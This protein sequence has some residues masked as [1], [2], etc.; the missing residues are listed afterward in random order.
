VRTTSPLCCVAPDGRTLAVGSGDTKL[1]LYDI[2]GQLIRTFR[3]AC[4]PV[5]SVAF[6]RM[7]DTRHGRRRMNVDRTDGSARLWNVET[8]KA[9]FRRLTEAYYAQVRFSP[10]GQD[11]G[12]GRLRSSRALLDAAT[13][14]EK[15]VTGIAVTSACQS[16]RRTARRHLLQH[17]RHGAFLGRRGTP[18]AESGRTRSA[19]VSAL[20][21]SPDGQVSAVGLRGEA[22]VSL[23]D[24]TNGTEVRRIAA[25]PDGVWCLTS[26]QTAR[27]SPAP[28]Q[29]RGTCLDAQTGAEKRRFEG[30]RDNQS[31]ASRLRRTA[32]L[33]GAVWDADGSAFCGTPSAGKSTA[34]ETRPHGRPSRLFAGRNP[35]GRRRS[36]RR[37]HTLGNGY[38]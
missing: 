18:G 9:I 4:R 37:R 3:G 5:C 28:V 22:V 23:R 10:D 7:A 14:R 17:R 30:P 11:A 35:S 31:S 36:P 16:S 15:A 34:S 20:A 8:G 24:A 25:K 32:R 27:P 6:R 26:R 33:A 38:R 29:R 2:S 21:L 12:L 19:R 1:R 13:G